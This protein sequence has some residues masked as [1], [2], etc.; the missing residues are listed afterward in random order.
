MVIGRF[1]GNSDD[2]PHVLIYGHYDVQPANES[3][4]KS[5]PFSLQA[6]DGYLYGRGVSDNKVQRATQMYVKETRVLC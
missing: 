2:A 1:T 3:S 4:W 6:R 5:D